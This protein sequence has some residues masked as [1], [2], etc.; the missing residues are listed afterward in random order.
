MLPRMAVRT[1][2]LKKY[3]FMTYKFKLIKLFIAFDAKAVVVFINQMSHH[4]FTGLSGD[5]IFTNKIRKANASV[6]PFARATGKLWLYNPYT[7]HKRVPNVKS[8]YIKDEMDEG[9]LSVSFLW[10]VVKKMLL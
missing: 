7:N 6:I 5:L 8:T 3:F 10:P 4:L 2:N 1:N 9:L